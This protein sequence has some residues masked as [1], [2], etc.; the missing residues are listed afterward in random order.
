[1]SNDNSREER[2]RLREEERRRRWEQ[3][4]RRWK[5]TDVFAAIGAVVG[6]IVA[7][8]LAIALI[9]HVYRFFFHEDEAV[10]DFVSQVQNDIEA[11]NATASSWKIEEAELEVSIV[12]KEGSEI[13][14]ESGAS[15][16]AL[17]RGREQTHR[18]VLKL[19]KPPASV[20]VNSAT[21][22][23]PCTSS[24]AATATPSLTSD[25]G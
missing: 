9:G 16:G 15:G 2:R 6:C 14:V 11:I 3:E 12:G 8:W 18:L 10:Q 17:S 5:L 4:Q 13:K 25:P 23:V 21:P 20:V 7:I 1:M 22:A 24:V 19:R